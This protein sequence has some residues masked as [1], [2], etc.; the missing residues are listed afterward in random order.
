MVKYGRVLEYFI[1]LVATI[2]SI[3]TLYTSFDNLLRNIDSL[4]LPSSIVSPLSAT[5]VITDAR[6][7]LQ[8]HGSS[9]LIAQQDMILRER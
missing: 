2:T 6:Y 9:Y 1:L 4:T 7:L 5:L 3:L 8:N